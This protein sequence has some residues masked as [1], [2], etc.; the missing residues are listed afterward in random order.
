MPDMWHVMGVM[1]SAGGSVK[2]FHD[3]VWRTSDDADRD[4][5]EAMFN[6][7]ASVE[8]GCEGLTFLPYLTGE[9]TP[10]AD[11]YARG[12][13]VGL[14]LRHDRAHMARAV[15]EG[16]TFG[17]MDGLT[18]VRD[19]GVD[20][21]RVRISGGGAQNPFWRQMLADVFQAEV[22]TIN[23]TQGAAFGAAILALVG[24]G[25]TEDVATAC[26][27]VVRETSTTTPQ[28]GYGYARAYEH[29][30]TMYPALKPRFAALHDT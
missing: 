25:I 12:A 22:A 21:P 29:Y 24:G 1:L 7:A 18:L 6:A 2:W 16:V 23:V 20:V 13:F 26:R 11:P 5:Y 27:S 9:R 10:H 15:I 3:N 8:P 17:L 4:H 14:T 30:R 28:P 19:M